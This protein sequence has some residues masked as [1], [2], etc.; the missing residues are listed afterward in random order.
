MIALGGYIGSRTGR[1]DS[2][3][4]ID[5]NIEAT[6]TSDDLVDEVLDFLFMPHIGAHK[7]G[8]SAEVAQF[9]G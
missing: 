6:E 4:V 3:S 8:L 5:G 2:T 7:F 1:A 9:S